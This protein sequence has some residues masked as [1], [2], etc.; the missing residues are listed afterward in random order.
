MQWMMGLVLA[1][2]IAQADGL[3]T[4]VTL[5]QEAWSGYQFY[6]LSMGSGSGAFAVSPD[7]RGWGFS[8]CSTG[9]CSGDYQ[10]LALAKCKER[11]QFECLVFALNDRIQI[12]YSVQ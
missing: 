7:G 9:S 8:Y 6:I 3:A 12:K 4:T 5:S 1:L 2:Q 10:A 11:A